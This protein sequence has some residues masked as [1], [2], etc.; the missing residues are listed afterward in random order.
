MKKNLESHTKN[1]TRRQNGRVVIA[2]M[3]LV[4][5]LLASCGTPEKGQVTQK[6]EN[7]SSTVREQVTVTEDASPTLSSVNPVQSTQAI[8]AKPLTTKTQ[9][10]PVDGMTLVF[11]PAGEFLMG[12]EKGYGDD[13]ELPQHSIR[14]TGYWIDQTEVTNGMYSKCVDAGV[15]SRPAYSYSYSHADY[16]GNSEFSDYPVIYVDWYQATKY[17][18]WAGRRLPTEAEWEFAARGTQSLLYPWGNNLPDDTLT[19]YNYQVGDVT[20]TG[21]YPA[22]ASPYGVLDLAGNVAEW[23]SDWYG[24]YQLYNDPNPQGVNDGKYR[25]LRGGSYMM[26]EYMLRTAERYWSSAYFTSEDTGFRCAFSEK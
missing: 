18:K 9:V 21:S 10:S 13:D 1:V 19:N 11:I 4:V 25:L 23:V 7:P 15:C 14:M 16:F 26:D 22:G 17:C 24:S 20:K 3:G 8:T 2:V 12:S 5:F 6:T